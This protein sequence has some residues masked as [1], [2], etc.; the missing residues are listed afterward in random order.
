M[1]SIVD[2][3]ESKAHVIRNGNP[4]VFIECPG[5]GTRKSKCSIH[6]T[7]GIGNCFRASC[8]LNG[9]FNFATLIT[10]LS[11]C[12]YSEALG[13][14]AR[15]SD[16][17]ELEYKA[18]SYGLN[19]SYPKNALPIQEML[20]FAATQKNALY[21][22]LTRNAVEYLVT[23]RNLSQS[24]IEK[25]Q[26]GVGYEDF[27]I[28]EKAI[29]RYGMIVVPLFF[30]GQIVSYVERSIEVRGMQLARMKHYKPLEQEEYLTS[31]QMLFNCDV[32]IPLA[33]KRG[34][35][36]IV[37]DA[38]SAIAIGNAVATTDSGL[39]DDQIFIM[40]TN[41][42][43]P[44]AVVRDNDKG[45]EEAAKKDILKLSKYYEDVRVIKVDGTDPTDNLSS[46]LDKIKTSTP[47][48]LFE[49]NLNNIVFR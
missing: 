28:G 20:N 3:L 19:R 46:T 48:D 32:A 6:I 41:W 37:E 49:E 14:A 27:V 9:G 40:T 26:L 35:L 38:W 30:N 4:N 45:G 7:K 31:S 12:S 34:I 10:Y 47:V 15:Y 8:P 13:I 5:C 42:K 1:A 2:Y 21:Y 36:C 25:Y 29:P 16:E 22:D 11:N 44:I 43:G 17:I 39:S 33:Q 23:K 18:K 24:Q